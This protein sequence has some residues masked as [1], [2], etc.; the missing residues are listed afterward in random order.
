ME[1]LYLHFL[2][3]SWCL[4]CD[5]L[6]AGRREAR[7]GTLGLEEASSITFCLIYVIR[8]RDRGCTGIRLAHSFQETFS[9]ITTDD[10]LPFYSRTFSMLALNL[11]LR[12][13]ILR[14]F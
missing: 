2:N 14:N 8:G 12:S 1:S 4:L 9:A 11:R 5:S 6:P 3:L 13:P 10:Y 7:V